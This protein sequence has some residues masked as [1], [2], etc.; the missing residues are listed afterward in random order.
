MNGE[1]RWNS[2][3]SKTIVGIAATV[4]ML[5]LAASTAAAHG[6]GVKAKGDLI[7]FSNP[8]GDNRSNP[9][10]DG[11]TAKVHSVDTDHGS[12]TVTLHVKGLP[13]NRTF[14]AHVHLLACN[15]N[16][17]GGH[18]RNHPNAP[19]SPD[20]EIWLDFTTNHAGNGQARTTVPF[21][22]RSGEANAVVIHDHETD[23]NGVAGAK[24][25]C[26]DVDF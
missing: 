25:A 16:K 2:K 11:A 3:T 26:L 22:I 12:T 23:A 6:N 1:T 4:A 5:V 20:N 21:V 13:A 15:D 14:G 24:L 9:I 17:A 19:A 10:G 7:L 8:Y 18:Y